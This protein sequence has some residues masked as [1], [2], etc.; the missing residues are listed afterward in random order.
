MRRHR[1]KP[2]RAALV[3]LAWIA[4]TI[5]ASAAD[6]LVGHAESLTRYAGRPPVGTQYK[7]TIKAGQ[8]GNPSVLPIPVDPATNGGAIT[9]QRDGGVLADPLTAGTW[10]GMGTPPG[11]RGWQ[12]RNTAAPTGG[13]VQQ[14][15]FTARVIK[16]ITKGTGTMP[17]PAATN[18]PIETV[19]VADGAKYCTRAVAPW[20]VEIDDKLIKSK[21]QMPPASC[22][23]ILG[24][25]SDGDRLDDCFETNTGIFVSAMDTGTNPAVADTDGDSI[26]DGDE[27]L[28]T[29]GGLNLPALGTSPV[30]KD[31]LVEYDWFDDALECGAHSHRPTSFAL[32]QVTAAFAA[33]PIS[34]PDGVSGIHFIHDYGQGG[35][36]T[37]GNR[38]PDDD[39]ILA[40]GVNGSEF[41]DRKSPNFAA[42]RNGYFHYV[43][44]PH[45]YNVTSTSSGQAELPGDDAIVS[46]YC[47]ADFDDFVADTIMHE[48]GHNLGLRHGGFEDCNYK[49]NYNS[50]MNYL[51]QFSGI[52]TNCT[53]T[54]NGVLSYSIGAR[55]PLDE[56][57]LDE[58]AG[59]CGGVPLDWNANSVIDAGVVTADLN[60]SDGQQ[61]STCGGTLTTL[62]DHDD[63][64][65]ISLGGISDGD[66]ARLTPI[67]VVECTNPVPF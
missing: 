41:Q 42:N 16:L 8:N 39:G 67:E 23:C 22:D 53:P 26:N 46:L 51:Y 12:Y 27:V 14:L 33:A 56:S 48:L 59:M 21:N 17:L 18:A 19:I 34:N 4:L 54:G 13:A 50:V 38:I 37:G 5:D 65:N 55:M 57:S 20:A 64:L 52:D 10:K 30:H 49:P 11:S 9:V 36:F 3:I 2:L 25:D 15:M 60:P 28:G 32:A 61:A 29:Q 35:R 63:W 24:L 40:T 47:A 6:N 66:G 7:I 1:V 45:R 58:N 31:I 43:L 44:L 62:Q